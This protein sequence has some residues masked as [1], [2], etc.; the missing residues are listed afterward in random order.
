MPIN[1]N[2]EAENLEAHGVSDVLRLRDPVHVVHKRMTGYNCFDNNL[3]YFFH[4]FVW[5]TAILMNNFQYGPKAALVA[6]FLVL[7]VVVVV[8]IAIILIII[9]LV[10]SIVLLELLIVFVYAIICQVDIHII[11]VTVGRPLIRFSGESG[12]TLLM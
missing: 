11:H 9:V 5:I 6:S 7:L 12:Q 1:H 3:F 2:V 4:D 10:L 8:I